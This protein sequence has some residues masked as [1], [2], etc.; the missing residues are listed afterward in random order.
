[1]LYLVRAHYQKENERNMTGVHAY[2]VDAAD[3]ATARDAAFAAAPTGECMPKP[4]WEAVPL[5]A[6]LTPIVV[7]GNVLVLKNSERLRGA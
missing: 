7:Q 3:E 2:I 5:S 4:E 1:M 6:D